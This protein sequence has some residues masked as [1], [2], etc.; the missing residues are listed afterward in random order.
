M[1]IN[2]YF[3][4][5][6]FQIVVFTVIKQEKSKINKII[7]NPARKEPPKERKLASLGVME[8]EYMNKKGINQ[9]RMLMANM[10]RENEIKNIELALNEIG[11]Q[12]EEI[13]ETLLAKLS[14]MNDL[15]ERKKSA[16]RAQRK[17]YRIEG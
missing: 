2:F 1:K 17:A 3:F 8:D 15:I 13:N 16:E 4:F 14:E 10:K 12:V 9:M 7:N 6:I 5:F 11:D